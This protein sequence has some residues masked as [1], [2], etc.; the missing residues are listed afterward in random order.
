VPL[1][2]LARAT[3]FVLGAVAAGLWLRRRQPPPP[4]LRQETGELPPVPAPQAEPRP[5]TAAR[6]ARAAG[7]AMAR[8]ARRRVDIVTI[9]DDLLG[10][11]R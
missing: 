4:A 3:P 10:A 9:V 8:L 1:R 2:L 6:A 7:P 11:A 5:G